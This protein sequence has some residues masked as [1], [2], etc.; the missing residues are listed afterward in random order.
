MV[1]HRV[2]QNYWKQAALI[3]IVVSCASGGRDDPTIDLGSEAG[4]DDSWGA[5]AKASL[6]DAGGGA[7]AQPEMPLNPSHITLRIPK[8]PEVS[9]TLLGG[10]KFPFP[11][12][13]MEEADHLVITLYMPQGEVKDISLR[14]L[15][16][17]GELLGKPIN[18][19]AEVFAKM[20]TNALQA[21]ESHAIFSFEDDAQCPLRMGENWLQGPVTSEFIDGEDRDVMHGVFVTDVDQTC[22]VSWQGAQKVY[23]FVNGPP[24]CHTQPFDISVEA[25]QALGIYPVVTPEMEGVKI[26]LQSP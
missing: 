14:P 12:E 21:D 16:E 2:V 11:H 1:I 19:T 6:S 18:L 3:T 10:A 4:G 22:R 20:G 15:D 13:I 8:V 9:I 25:G 17:N 23:A 5:V 26:I 7:D 24:V